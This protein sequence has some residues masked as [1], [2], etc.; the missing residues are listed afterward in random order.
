MM[1]F[2]PDLWLFDGPAVTGAGGFR[3]PTR[4]A[5]VRLP[6]DGGLWVW[7]PVALTAE[8]QASVDA[9]GAVRHLIAPNSLH[10]TFLKEWA[11]AYPDA[12]VEAAPG[13]S[14]KTVGTAIHAPLGNTHDPAWAGAVDQV[15]VPGNRITTE[16]V[17]FHAASSTVFVTD[18]VQQIPN[19]WFN[20]WRALVARL[21]L[22]TAAVPSVPRK[23]RMA[24]TDRAAAR[25][26]VRRI[27]DW[28]AD[29]L[30]M[31]HGT[32][33]RE[34]GQQTLQNAFRWLTD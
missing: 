6:G 8:I 31:A 4:M 10:Y 13:L 15:T 28:P 17:F 12:I 29:Q 3:F 9:L 1:Q 24:T 32:P 34:G 33:L 25:K 21:D 14:P 16:V 27:L 26:A 18:L 20:G 23:F 2:G 5:V 22:M 7:S 30:V 11:Q 19:D